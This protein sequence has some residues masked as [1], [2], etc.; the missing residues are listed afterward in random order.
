MIRKVL[1]GEAAMLFLIVA[2]LSYFILE[3]RFSELEKDHVAEDTA[4]EAAYF[5]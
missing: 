5:N 4:G 3:R 2:I 1:T